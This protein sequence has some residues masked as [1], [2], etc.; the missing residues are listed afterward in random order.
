MSLVTLLLLT[1][2]RH[3]YH[4]SNICRRR[5]QW[6]VR[7]FLGYQGIDVYEDIEL[8]E[9]LNIVEWEMNFEFFNY[10]FRS[11]VVNEGNFIV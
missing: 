6:T 1:Y 2:F 5:G 10:K 3:T 7:L 4:H 11:Q 8:W 9:I